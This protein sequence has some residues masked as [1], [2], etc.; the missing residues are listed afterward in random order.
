MVNQCAGGSGPEVS[1]IRVVGC[2]GGQTFHLYGE[3]AGEEGAVLLKDGLRELFEAPVRVVERAPVRRDG[4]VLRAV[5][6]AVMEPV[7]RVGISR[8]LVN[9][10]FG[11]VDGAFREAFS[12]ELDPYYEDSRLA[13]IEWETE[14]GTRY[15]EVVLTG[16]QSYD[17]ELVPHR[18]GS[19][20]W[21]VHLKAYDPFWRQDTK[22]IAVEFATAGTKQIAIE[23]PTGVDLA[24][25]WIGTRGQYRLPDNT[26]GGAPWKRAP[27]G[28]FPDRKL[29][30]PN[31]TTAMGGIKITPDPGQVPVRDAYDHNLIAMMPVQGESP[32]HLIPR[33]T[34]KQKIPVEAVQVPAGGARLELHRT[35][36]YRKPWGRV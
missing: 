22:P 4:A 8:K 31:V 11:V 18:H 12:H 13:R 5:K 16:G 34:Q 7:L 26:W 3:G 30:Y 36:R 19:W 21:E 15:I 25:T 10:T 24:P 6:T 14:D 35:L 2:D 20:I 32:K 23:N 33:F 28:R 9:E 27:G 17:A 29:L 1:N